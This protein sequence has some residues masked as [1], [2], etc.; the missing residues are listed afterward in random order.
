MI[1]ADRT[2]IADGL[3]KM[4]E[5]IIRRIVREELERMAKNRP[6]IFYVEADMPLYEDMLEIRKRSKEK[7]TE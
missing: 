7:K 6:E 3:I 2:I 5:P 1:Q 4:M